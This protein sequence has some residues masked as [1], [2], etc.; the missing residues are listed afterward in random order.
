MPLTLRCGRGCK[1]FPRSSS[2]C[3][4]CA[5]A[6]GGCSHIITIVYAYDLYLCVLD[7]CMFSS[8]RKVPPVTARTRLG[9]TE[10]CTRAVPSPSLH[11]PL[12]RGLI[13]ELF[14]QR[15]LCSEERTPAGCGLWVGFPRW[16]PLTRRPSGRAPVNFW[17]H[18]IRPGDKYISVFD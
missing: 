12:K 18:Q 5:T 13:R 1:A 3:R 8:I 16:P 6:R 10:K 4:T 11:L 9:T 17:H 2:R 15:L 7:E 14:F